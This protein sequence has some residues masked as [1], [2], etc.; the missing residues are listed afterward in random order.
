M[1]AVTA[2]SAPA[3]NQL[4]R[5][6]SAYMAQTAS[7]FEIE[8]STILMTSPGVPESDEITAGSTCR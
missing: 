5:V 3:A 6:T 7:A 2:A 4:C 1:S 8:S